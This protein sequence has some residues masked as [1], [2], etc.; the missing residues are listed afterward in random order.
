MADN[1]YNRSRYSSDENWNEQ[2]HSGSR[3]NAY[4]DDNYGNVNYD[5]DSDSQRNQGNY[6]GSSSQSGYMGSR[7]ND[8]R[9]YSGGQQYGSSQNAGYGS[10]DYDR[11][12]NDWQSGS[13][14]GGSY[15]SDYGYQ[16]NSN[17]GGQ[18]RTSGGSYGSDYGRNDSNRN[19]GQGNTGMGGYVGRNYGNNNYGNM[20]SDR[21]S[22]NRYGGDTSNYGNANQGGTDRNWWDRTRDEVSSWFGSDDAER[23]RDQDRVNG[24]HKG[25]GP[26]GYQRSGDR[27]R[28]DVCDRL[29]DNPTIDASGIEVKMDGNDVVLTG[30]VDSR[31][32]K[33]RAEDIV[34]AVSG[35]SNVQN[36]LRVNRSE[37]GSTSRSSSFDSESRTSTDATKGR[38]V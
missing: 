34:E 5:R 33:R 15:S 20:G 30:T 1:N 7:G 18:Q 36:Q 38:S 28:E 11:R 29:S 19:Y 22:G 3:Q 6:G 4:N 37:G 8:S 17:Y 16:G 32:D 10:N 35:V 21:Y 26:K 12:N 31:E 27:I 13:G 2:K 14:H 23:R 25:K 24:P 9:N